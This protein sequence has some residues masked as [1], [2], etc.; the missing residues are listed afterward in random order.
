[1]IDLLGDFSHSPELHTVTFGLDLEKMQYSLIAILPSL[2]PISSTIRDVVFD[3]SE[4]NDWDHENFDHLV[5]RQEY[6][7][8]KELDEPLCQ[9]QFL[10]HQVISTNRKSGCM[11]KRRG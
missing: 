2:E 10:T 9:P 5:N 7:D 11:T 6:L 1:M 8:F 4:V 3:I